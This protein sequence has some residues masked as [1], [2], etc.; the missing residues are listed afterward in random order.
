MRAWM[1]VVCLAAV[2]AIAPVVAH[3]QNEILI[4]NVP[5]DFAVGKA[6]MPAGHYAVKATTTPNTFVIHDE[7][8]SAFVNTNTIETSEGTGH[9]ARMVFENADG[10]YALA[11]MWGNNPQSGRGVTVY[12]NGNKTKLAKAGVVEV[13]AGQ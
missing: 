12:Q 7:H 10:H 4:F 3:A 9:T 13:Q 1:A 2:V 8:H 11:E 5:F 6:V